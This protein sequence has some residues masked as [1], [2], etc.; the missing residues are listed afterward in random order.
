MRHVVAT[1]GKRSLLEGGTRCVGPLQHRF[2]Q[3]KSPFQLQHMHI[4]TRFSRFN[5]VEI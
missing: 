4:L 3:E 2:D 5:T 1:E